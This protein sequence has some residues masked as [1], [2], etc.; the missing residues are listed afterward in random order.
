MSR[1]LGDLP[2]ELVLNIVEWACEDETP[3]SMHKMLLVNRLF[4]RLV[5]P[6]LYKRLSEQEL[7]ANT[8]RSTTLLLK[9]LFDPIKRELV[10]VLDLMSYI[11]SAESPELSKASD[12]PYT[13]KMQAET[14]RLV[15]LVLRYEE[16]HEIQ[17]LWRDNFLNKSSKDAFFALALMC[18][19]NLKELGTYNANTDFIIEYAY[20]Y[21]GLL[22]ASKHPESGISRPFARIEKFTLGGDGNKYPYD[23][24]PLAFAAGLPSLKEISCSELGDGDNYH[25]EDTD[26]RFMKLE[27]KSSD[28]TSI[29]LRPRCKL[30]GEHLIRCLASV[31]ALEHFDYEIGHSW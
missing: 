9:L 18:L 12:S 2:V 25:Q 11:G 20:I 24:Y 31:K 14:H 27:P 3:Q 30:L 7:L 28:I 22:S 26:P 4:Y 8:D 13:K 6:Y 1:G 21:E 15:E 17:K 10:H 5:L 16:R 19:P 23:P 29:S